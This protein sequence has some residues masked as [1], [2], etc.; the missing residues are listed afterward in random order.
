MA[1]S[2]NPSVNIMFQFP[3]VINSNI[4]ATSVSYFFFKYWI[5][6]QLTANYSQIQSVLILLKPWI[7]RP[8]ANKEIISWPLIFYIYKHRSIA[9]CLFRNHSPDFDESL[10]RCT[11]AWTG[12]WEGEGVGDGSVEGVDGS[13]CL[14]NSKTMFYLLKLGTKSNGRF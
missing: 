3:S 8:F 5:N 9:V 10:V 1:V 2:W 14:L 7:K 11:Y 6:V 4:T 13:S 12:L